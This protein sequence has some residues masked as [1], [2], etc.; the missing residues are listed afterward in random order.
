LSSPSTRHLV[1]DDEEDPV[2]AV[3]VVVERALGDVRLAGDLRGRRVDVPLFGEEPGR[4]RK[5][6][7]ANFRV[8]PGIP[9]SLPADRVSTR[10]VRRF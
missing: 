7:G 8:S 1:E 5:D 10:S 2:L 6:G 4:G 9:P 3:E